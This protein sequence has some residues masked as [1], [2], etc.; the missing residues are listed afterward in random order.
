MKNLN[1]ELTSNSIL[2]SL[3]NN[4][5]TIAL[6]REDKLNALTCAMYTDFSRCLNYA[7]NTSSIRAVIIS[8][9]SSNFT[10]GN[11]IA[12]FINHPDLNNEHPVVVFLKI[13]ANFDKPLLACVQGAAVGIG[14]TLLFHCDFVFADPSAYFHMPFV[15]LGLVPEAG[16]SY[17]LPLI[18]NRNT[19]N[20]LLLLGRKIDAQ[21]ASDCGI[22]GELCQE[23]L[24]KTLEVANEIAHLPKS[25]VFETKKLLKA[26]IQS[27]LDKTIAMELAVFSKQLAS[28]EA[29]FAFAK[30]MSK[31]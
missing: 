15:H 11:D 23:P 8:S 2:I 1:E 17:L 12:D 27:V 18:T 26:P 14:T 30:F 3:E 29:K 10:A 28:D 20:E 4:T 16:S 13:L 31:T 5:L 9:T 25:A 6:N 19:A 21:K 24:K 22:I 7:S